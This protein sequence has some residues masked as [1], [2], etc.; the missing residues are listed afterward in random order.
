VTYAFVEQA[1]PLLEKKGIDLDVW[2]VA[3]TELFDMLP[4]SEQEKIF[5]DRAAQEAIGIT[6]FTPPTM[7]RWIRSAKGQEALLHPFKKGHYLGSGQGAMVLQEASLDGESQFKA[8]V[9]YLG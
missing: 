7:H 5:P 9:K 2:Y 8:I 3:S 1:L 6:G 4:K